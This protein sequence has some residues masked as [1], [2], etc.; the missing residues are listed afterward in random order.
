MLSGLWP[1]IINIPYGETGYVLMNREYG[2]ASFVLC[3]LV[4]RSALEQSS[5]LFTTAHSLSEQMKMLLGQC[6]SSYGW[7][8]LTAW[9][10]AESQVKPDKLKNIAR[11]AGS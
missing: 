4:P 7:K 1:I 2:A 6:H 3:F 9:I 8:T 5:A 10:Q 11:A